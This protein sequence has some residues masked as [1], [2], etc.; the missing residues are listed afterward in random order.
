MLLNLFNENYTLPISID[1]KEVDIFACIA[2]RDFEETGNSSW[3]YL[4][5]H[6]GIKLLHIFIHQCTWV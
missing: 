1:T 6:V 2:F 3:I 4:H 5:I